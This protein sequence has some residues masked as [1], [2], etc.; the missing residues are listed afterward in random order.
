MQWIVWIKLCTEGKKKNHLV[1][2]YVDKQNGAYVKLYAESSKNQ[3]KEI[4]DYFDYNQKYIVKKYKLCYDWRCT[5]SSPS[6]F[7]SQKKV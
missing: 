7:V 4:I 2:L 6:Y 5:D 1:V 3:K